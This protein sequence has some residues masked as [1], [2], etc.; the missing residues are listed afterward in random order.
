MMIGWQALRFAFLDTS[1]FGKKK[2]KR[3]V[4]FWY[5]RGVR[6]FSPS[7]F[8]SQH[9]KHANICSKLSTGFRLQTGDH[10]YRA[11]PPYWW[12]DCLQSGQTGALVWTGAACGENWIMKHM[13]FFFFPFPLLLLLRVTH[14]KDQRLLWSITLICARAAY[15]VC[16]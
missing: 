5:S 16:V 3:W 10:D 12:S 9:G 14:M 6:H 15:A 7:M 8:A 11:E 2:K 13:F 4:I 1:E